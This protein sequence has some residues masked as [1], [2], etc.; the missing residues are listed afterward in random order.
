MGLL[1][2]FKRLLGLERQGGKDAVHERGLPFGRDLEARYARA[3]VEQMRQ[4]RAHDVRNGIY[5][6]CAV[7]FVFNHER[8]EGSSVTEDMTRTILETRATGRQAELDGEER[9]TA[10]HL[11]LFDEIIDTA[12]EELS[13][14]LIKRLHVALMGGTMA[15]AGQWKTLPNAVSDL[16]TCAPGEVEEAMGE[17]VGSYLAHEATVDNIAR[18]HARFE[19][20]HPFQDGNGRVGRAVAFRECLHAGRV[21][22]IV[23]DATKEE[24]YSALHDFQVGASDRLLGYFHGRQEE[25]ARRYAPLLAD[26]VLQS[27]VCEALGIETGRYIPAFAEF[28]DKQQEASEKDRAATARL[29]RSTR[30]VVAAVGKSF[31][32]KEVC[33][34]V[35]G[36]IEVERAEKDSS[37]GA[38]EVR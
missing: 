5:E 15:C 8:L 9:Q 26:T 30:E 7:S 37:R 34:A 1:G 14:G 24:Y 36:G 32:D 10:N 12:E 28:C 4:E 27:E 21:P 11:A 29:P 17:L 22:L 20:I 13:L 16:H 18:F 38:A 2:H 23:T 19:S 33:S 31:M 35:A 25:F 6:T 3:I